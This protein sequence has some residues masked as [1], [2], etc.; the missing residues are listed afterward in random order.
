M[1]VKF[2]VAVRASI[3]LSDDE[4]EGIERGLEDMRGGQFATDEEIAA[5]FRR[6]RS[7]RA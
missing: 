2:V 1:H 4:R 3:V 7:F 5:I 6:A